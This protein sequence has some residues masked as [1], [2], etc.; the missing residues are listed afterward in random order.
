VLTAITVTIIVTERNF[1]S[2]ILFFVRV[3]WPGDP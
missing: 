3:Q 1:A 2:G